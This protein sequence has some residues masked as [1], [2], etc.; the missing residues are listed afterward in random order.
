MVAAPMQQ[1]VQESTREV[2]PLMS[3]RC[4][5]LRLLTVIAFFGPRSLGQQPLGATVPGRFLVTYRAGTIPA[6]AEARIQA[7]GAS[8]VRRHETL[9]IAVVQTAAATAAQV[10]A[11]LAAD[12]AVASVVED[13][14]VSAHVLQVRHVASPANGSDSLYNSPQGWAVRQVGGLGDSTTPGPW[15][16]TTGAG[17][18]IA[19][20][21]SGVDAT[22]PDIAPN[23]ALNLTEIDQGAATGLP[24]PCDDGTPQDQTG[25]G[26]WTASLAAAAM[27]PQTGLVAGVAPSATILNIKVLERLPSAATSA[28]DPTGCNAGQASGLLSWVLAGIED[29]VDNHANIISMSL[30]T[31]IDLTTGDGAGLQATFDQVTHAAANAGVILIASAGNDGFNL[32][33]QRYIELPAQSRDVLAI[34][35]STNPACAENLA[36][37]A[38]CA[39][40]AVTL[41]YYSNSGATLNAL[42]APGGSYPAGPDSDTTQPSGWIWGACSNGIPSTTS[43]APS[44]PEHSFG[45]FGLGHTSYVQAMGT[46]ASAPL[47]AGAAALILAANPTW[48]ASQVVD[49]LRSS[50]SVLSNLTAPE[51]NVTALFPALLSQQFQ[52]IES[53]PQR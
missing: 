36:A 27:G 35:A 1:Q 26:T 44:D 3:F 25:H 13:R 32:S 47:T 52:H 53:R 29:A 10:R 5:L 15:N 33:N 11:R 37:N 43:G 21:D 8:L 14:I 51:V 49:A 46:S 45:C 17:V 4:F 34:V 2:L 24:S 18:R 38:I 50:A 23:L 31:L 48:T 6:A 22:H 20:L 19:I 42:A 7:A 40:G 41:P 9:G 16:T 28:S 30:G 12:P 39:P